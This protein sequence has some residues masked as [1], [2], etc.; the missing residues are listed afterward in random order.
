MEQRDDV[1]PAKTEEELKEIV[2][3]YEG[4]TRRLGGG[5]GILGTVLTVAMSLY[6]LYAAQVPIIQQ[7]HLVRHLIFVLVL[8]F[9][10]Y[11]GT[12]KTLKRTAPLLWDVALV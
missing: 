7:V 6:H 1:A 8:T 5:W 12:Q 4:K 3:E 11:P 10:L 2:E 9:L